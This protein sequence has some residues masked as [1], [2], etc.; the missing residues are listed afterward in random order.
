M[1]LNFKNSKKII[2]IIIFTVTGFL[3]LQNL[4]TVIK[5][6]SQIIS[7][8][9]PFII[10]ICLAFILNVPLAF[11]ENKLFNKIKSNKLKR[12]I[13][14]LCTCLIIFTI[15]TS[16]YFFI[17][18]KL[19][20]SFLMLFKNLPFY[21]TRFELWV[22]KLSKKFDVINISFLKWNEIFNNLGTSAQRQ[23]PRLL[24]GTMDV[25]IK[26]IG[27]IANFL[28]GF[29]LSIYILLQKEKL[30]GNFK[31][32]IF[33]FLKKE[34]AEH[35]LFIGKLSNEIFSK[36]VFGQFTEVLIIGVLC[37]LGMKVL[38][39]PYALLI[40]S[41]ISVSAF[42]PFLG[43]FIGTLLGMFLLF[44][45]KPVSA[46]W[47]L[48]FII[49]LQQIE[50]N[51]IY[52]R[53]V[54]NSI[55]LPGIWVLSAVVIGGNLL[56]IIGMILSVPIVALIYTLFKKSVLKRLREKGIS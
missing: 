54:G 4:E 12:I 40:S 38:K 25:L 33:A 41:I 10:G 23:M 3:I 19:Q 21:L 24:N 20:E 35:I 28:I 9:S 53:V 47:F 42:I 16:L 13:S 49:I 17:I 56:G 15:I 2:L 45:V 52:P 22:E 39:L 8:F 29:V 5:I 26:T 37:F 6:F 46:L 36:F 50:G 11:L 44:M 55:G 32:I 14:L 18:P 43:A 1:E 51:I 27:K 31:K 7:I 30:S 34:K 48:I